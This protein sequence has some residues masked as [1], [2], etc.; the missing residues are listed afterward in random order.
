MAFMQFM[1]WKYGRHIAV[2]ASH[3]MKSIFPDLT[4]VITPFRIA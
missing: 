2:N 1:V 4:Q 3:K